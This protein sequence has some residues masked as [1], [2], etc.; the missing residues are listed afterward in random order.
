MNLLA[1]CERCFGLCCVA[2]PFFASAD[3][4][5]DKPAGRPCP[6]PAAGFPLRHPHPLRE[7]G[8]PGC[9]VYDCFGAGQQVAQVTFGGRDWRQ[10]PETAEPD[11]R[12]VPGDAATCTNCS[13]TSREAASDP[14]RT[15]GRL[16]LFGD[17]DRRP[18]TIDET[19]ISAHRDVV[20]SARDWQ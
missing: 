16:E 3:F 12:G 6:Q 18:R 19:R 14:C 4:A 7:R 13:G 9:T 5:I 10:A 2:L 20:T 1:D 15:S 17:R 11:V 8:F